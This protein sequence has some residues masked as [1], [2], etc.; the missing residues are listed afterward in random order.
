MPSAKERSRP[1][2]STTPGIPARKSGIVLGQHGERGIRGSKLAQHRLDQHAG[3]TV[4]L[5]D[6]HE[7][8]GDGWHGSGAFV[9]AATRGPASRLQS[10]TVRDALR[11]ANRHRRSST[12]KHRHNRSQGESRMRNFCN[13]HGCWRSRRPRATLPALAQDYPNRPVKFVVP[14]SPGAGTD[15]TGRIVAEGLSKRLG[16]AGGRGEQGGRRIDDRHRIRREVSGRWLHAPLR[17]CRRDHR[18]AGREHQGAVQ[19][20]RRRALPDAHVHD[21]VLDC[22][23]QQ[24]AG[25]YLG[26]VHRLCQGQSRQGPLCDLRHRRRRSSRHGAA[27]ENRRDL[28]DPHSLQGRRSIHSRPSVR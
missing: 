15:A 12:A 26:R 4:A 13:G 23:Q 20:S 8:V 16:Q 11:L 27:R 21:A 6:G 17:D 9:D 28:D 24:P 1:V 10:K 25:Q 22:R 5:D 19:G 3:R 14:F 18:A 2:S 7:A